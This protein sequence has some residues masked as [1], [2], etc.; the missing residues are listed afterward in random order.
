MTERQRRFAEAYSAGA[1]AAQAAAQAGYSPGRAKRQAEALLRRGDVAEAIEALRRKR[2][3]AVTMERIR[4]ELAQIAF[5][6]GG[7]DG[8][9]D[10]DRLRALEMLTKLLPPDAPDEDGAQGCGVVILPEIM[11]GGADA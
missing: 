8:A 11:E 7:K 4:R 9:R 5:S 1:D 6:E 10:G 2:G 3:G